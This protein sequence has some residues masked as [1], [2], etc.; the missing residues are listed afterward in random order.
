[1]KQDQEREKKANKKVYALCYISAK[2]EKKKEQNELKK[3][4]KHKQGKGEKIR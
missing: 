2:H 4:A 3:K 1:M